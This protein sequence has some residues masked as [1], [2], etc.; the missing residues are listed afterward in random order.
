LHRELLDNKYFILKKLGFGAF[1]TVWLALNIKDR[2]LYALKVMR[3]AEK[4]TKAS[5][6]EDKIN[7]LVAESHNTPA[8]LESVKRYLGRPANRDDTHCL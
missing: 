7:H 1:S 8:W 5:Y 4:Y 3:S 2:K 6:T